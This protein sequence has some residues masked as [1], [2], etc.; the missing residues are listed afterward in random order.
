MPRSICGPTSGR[1]ASSSTSSLSGA[2]PWSGELTEIVS[3]IL[4]RDPVPLRSLSPRISHALSDV[5]SRCMRREP[6]E[7]WQSAGELARALAPY[8]TGA[9]VGAIE[10]INQALS[11]AQ[12]VRAARRFESFDNALQALESEGQR[13]E[14]LSSRVGA[15]VI[16]RRSRLPFTATWTETLPPSRTDAELAVTCLPPSFVDDAPKKPA[17]RILLIDDSA[18]T[19]AAQSHV[20][21]E[22][23]FDVRPARSPDE[24]EALLDGWRPHLVLMDVMM[25]ELSGEDLCRRVKARF[26]ATVPVVLVSDLPT[27]ELAA[28]AS[29]AGADGYLS[30][31]EP[32]ICVPRVRP[33]HLCDHVLARR[34]P[35]TEGSE[36][37]GGEGRARAVYATRAARRGRRRSRGP[38]RDRSSRCRRRRTSRWR[39]SSAA[40]HRALRGGSGTS[41]RGVPARR[42]AS[43]GRRA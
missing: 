5:V 24:F 42:C 43:R 25:P 36:A 21:S 29:A 9:W 13:D 18:I 12:P 10:C 37:R 11:S 27:E 16:S 26:K 1:S 15:V 8:G 39:S 35:V 32:R 22:D 7:R 33:Q 23:G 6:S 31:A 34:P 17:L 4:G 14:R 30:K 3:A 38:C 40:R 19:L 20:L 41:T 2:P 28:R